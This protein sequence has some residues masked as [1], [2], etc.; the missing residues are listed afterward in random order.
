M[1]TLVASAYSASSEA[2]RKI[3]G[4]L[5]VA[6]GTNVLEYGPRQFRAG[7]TNSKPLLVL[8]S[9]IFGAP[10][11]VV[12]DSAGDLWV[13][14]GGTVAA[15]GNVVPALDEFTP[16]QLNA[17]K[18]TPDPM[19]AV[20]I[21]SVNFGF[22][23]Q[24]VFLGGNLWVSDNLMNQVFAFAANQLG[25]SGSITPNVIISSSPV[26]SGPL[27]I[28]FDTSGDLFIANNADTNIYEFA[29]NTLP[30]P[31][32]SATVTLTPSVILSNDGGNSIQAPWALVFD[33]TGNLWSSNANPPF[34]LVA[35]APDQL[36]TT[37]APTPRI[38]ISPTTLRKRAT[39]TLIAPNGI[40]FDRRGRLAAAN[41]AIPFGIALFNPK[42]LRKNAMHPKPHTLISGTSTQLNAPAGDNFGPLI[43][44]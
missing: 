3:V 27:G 33:A 31:T 36:T 11:G 19:P 28:V 29:A 14:D 12:F 35:F 15:G 16:T 42:Q 1:L 43:N 37:G 2:A 10:Q 41:S 18:K 24:A 8:N 44:K 25:T 30:S 6:N 26:F 38:T 4:G 20:Q 39:P 9:P 22:P 13:I 32:T 40:A 21:T 7:L 34:T 23:Q 17:L 5:W